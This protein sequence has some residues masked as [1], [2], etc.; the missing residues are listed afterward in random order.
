MKILRGIG[1]ALVWLLATVVMLVAAVLCITVI[2]L[3]LGVPLMA[4]GLRLY[5][6]GVQLIIPRP[7]PVERGKKTGRK[8]RKQAGKKVRGV[9]DRAAKT[10]K[11]GRKR[12][13]G[14]FGG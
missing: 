6:Y 3:P 4:L 1:A 10:T 8:V 7:K 2:L 5:G 11:H 9:S 14:V 12:L 13:A